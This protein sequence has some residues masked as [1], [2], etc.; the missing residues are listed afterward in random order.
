MTFKIVDSVPVFQGYSDKKDRDYILDETKK[1]NS[2]TD[3]NDSVQECIN[4]IL[5]ELS[6]NE[7]KARVEDIDDLL[8]SLGYS[9]RNIKDAKHHLYENKMIETQKNGKG[10][11]VDMVRVYEE[12]S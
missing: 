8:K 10:G 5:S 11:K 12:K 9:V 7:G 3:K 2:K 1:K 4:I 6:D